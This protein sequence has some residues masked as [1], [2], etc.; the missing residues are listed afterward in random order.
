MSKLIHKIE[1]CTICGLDHSRKAQLKLTKNMDVLFVAEVINPRNGLE[2]LPKKGFNTAGYYFNKLLDESDATYTYCKTNAVLCPSLHATT[3]IPPVY[4]SNCRKWLRE[5]IEYCDPRVVVP[6]G[7]VA[8]TSCCKI[9]DPYGIN[10]AFISGIVGRAK[11]WHGRYLFPLIHTSGNAVAAVRSYPQM[12][13]DF[14]NLAK[15]VDDL[16]FGEDEVNDVD[17]GAKA[18]GSEVTSELA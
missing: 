8:V 18:T 14:R 10:G 16:K 6:L 7:R 4:V 2:V 15:F 13:R 5:V 1:G 11:V 3:H 12:L 17:D 9:Q